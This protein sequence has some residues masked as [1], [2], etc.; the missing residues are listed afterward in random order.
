M[1]RRRGYTLVEMVLVIGALSAV[2]G[3]CVAVIGALMTL[4]RAGRARLNEGATL[5]RLARQL[6]Q[7]ARAASKGE[8]TG[9]RQVPDRRLVLTLPDDRV[10][11][12]EW[13]AG[14]LLRTERAPG[15]PERRESFRLPLRG[16]PR[17]RVAEDGGATW[18]SLVFERKPG[19][20]PLIPAHDYRVEA[21]LGKDRRLAERGGK[22]R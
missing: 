16:A 13:S 7:D 9:R 12:Y 19:E 11:G 5:A 6:R 10:V 17:F 4:D 20:A 14:R 22:A 3:L 18:V 1:K 2:L 21:R 15:G 8:V